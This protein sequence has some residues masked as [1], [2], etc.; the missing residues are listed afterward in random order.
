MIELIMSIALLVVMVLILLAVLG[1]WLDYRADH[2]RK[3]RWARE[4][5]GGDC[6]E[7]D[8]VFADHMLLN[9][10]GDPFDGGD[11]VCPYDGC[12]CVSTLSIS[13]GAAE[14][15]RKVYP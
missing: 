2:T 3:F 8:H 13:S 6:R 7:C 12:R 11:L 1:Y 10:S 5:A 4:V 9:R 14:T 15:S